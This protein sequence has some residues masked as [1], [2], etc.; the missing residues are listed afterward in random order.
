MHM[1]M[2]IKQIWWVYYFEYFK[3]EFSLI[4]PKWNEAINVLQIGD[5]FNTRNKK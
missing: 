5:S 3:I 2:H 4:R 1:L